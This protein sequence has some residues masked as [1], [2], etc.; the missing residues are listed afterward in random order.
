M[1][2]YSAFANQIFNRPR[3]YN[4]DSATSRDGGTKMTVGAKCWISGYDWGVDEETNPV[5]LLR[6]ALEESKTH[7]DPGSF[8]LAAELCDRPPA[9]RPSY[10]KIISGLLNQ[11]GLRRLDAFGRPILSR[12]LVALL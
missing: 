1:P 2:D 7:F 10:T 6:A 9:L 12:K 4:T 3:R 11:N 5:R 8:D